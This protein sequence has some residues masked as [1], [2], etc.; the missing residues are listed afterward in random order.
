MDKKVDTTERPAVAPA[1]ISPMTRYAADF[2]KVFVELVKAGKNGHVED[3][4]PRDQPY[5]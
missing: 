2:Q 4:V 5:E 1:I 3:I